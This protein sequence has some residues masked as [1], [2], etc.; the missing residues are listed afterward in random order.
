MDDSS[1]TIDEAMRLHSQGESQA[2]IAAYEAILRREPDNHR[3]ANLLGRLFGVRG[4][5]E[6]AIL[7]L[8]KAVELAPKEIPYQFHLG[9][10]L[11]AGQRFEDAERTLRRA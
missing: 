4:D 6:S 10:T 1:I 2:A 5:H 3:A 8:H 11:F 7:L 9:Q